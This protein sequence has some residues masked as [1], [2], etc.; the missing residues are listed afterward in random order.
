MA[1]SRSKVLVTGGAGLIGSH[2]VDLLFGKGYPVVILDNLNPQTHPAGKPDWVH[3]EAEFI[4]GDVRNERD[5]AKSLEGVRYVVHQAAFGG[6]TEAVSEYFDVNVNGTARIFEVIRSRRLPVEKIV[7]ASSQAVYAEGAYECPK[8]GPQFPAP[9]TRAEEGNWE[10]PCP[11]CAGP[12]RPLPTPETKPLAGE[13]PYALSKEFEERFSLAAGRDLGIPVA[14]LRYAVT[15]GP[16]QSLFNPYTGVVSIF[17]TRIQNQLPPHLYED[18]RQTRDFVYVE[19]VA[20]ANLL[21]LEHSGIRDAAF[22]VGTG[23]ST[24]VGDLASNLAVIYGKK[25]SPEFSGD[26]RTGDVRHIVLDPGKIRSFGFEPKVS[27]EGG[28]RRVAEW[29]ASQG[30]IKEYFGEAYK[31]LREKRII[32]SRG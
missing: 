20:R 7:V 19:D 27:L 5:V 18:G 2:I 6:F 11:R 14:A 15:Y 16:R 28:L 30:E 22:N 17:S 13:T 32:R 9:R 10:V 31:R 3:H 1:A 29:I 23:R 25:I 12:L 4:Q 26:F 21:A 24:S 8:D